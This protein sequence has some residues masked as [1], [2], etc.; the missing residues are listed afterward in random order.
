MCFVVHVALDLDLVGAASDDADADDETRVGRS[1]WAC[2]ADAD[3]SV[4]DD[5]HQRF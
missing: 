3:M 2:A 4:D 1:R 5:H